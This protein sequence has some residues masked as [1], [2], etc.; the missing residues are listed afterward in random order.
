MG[1][2]KGRKVPQSVKTQRKVDAAVEAALKQQNQA[3]VKVKVRDDIEIEQLRIELEKASKQPTQIIPDY[4]AGIFEEA[5]HTGWI[6]KNW[7]TAW[8][9]ISTWAFGLIGYIAVFGIPQ[10]ILVLIPEAYQL[11]VIGLIA[12]IGFVGRFINQSKSKPL[13]PASDTLKESADV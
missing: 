6:V 4:T 12:L 9:W 1:L 8:K 7:H 13:P 5:L 11:K 3:Y 2:G 10:E